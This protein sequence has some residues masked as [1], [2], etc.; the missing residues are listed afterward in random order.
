MSVNHPFNM[1]TKI[2]ITTHR[3][4]SG[5]SVINTGTSCGHKASHCCAFRPQIEGL[6]QSL[7]SSRL[8]IAWYSGIASRNSLTF[9]HSLD[10]IGE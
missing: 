5:Y 7:Y 8:F 10:T 2:R 1:R 3:N 6:D 9:E 4:E